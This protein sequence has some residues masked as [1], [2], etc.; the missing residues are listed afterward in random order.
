[1]V[2]RNRLKTA[3]KLHKRIHAGSSRVS[4]AMGVGM[5]KATDTVEMLVMAAQESPD[6]A[7]LVVRTLYG[8]MT[9]LTSAL[10]VQGQQVGRILTELAPAD[11][12]ARIAMAG[13]IESRVG[14]GGYCY[15]A[16]KEASHD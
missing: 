10:L 8:Q 6:G 9:D 5:A 1:M 3:W 16:L 4:L 13:R 2:A 14:P 7:A 12:K 11:A 15:I